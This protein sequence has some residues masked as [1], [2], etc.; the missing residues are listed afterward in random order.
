MHESE[1]RKLVLLVA[2]G[3]RSTSYYVV[4][5]CYG[6]GH[7]NEQRASQKKNKLLAIPVV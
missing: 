5:V 7:D 3:E 4:V 6:M 1:G 2:N